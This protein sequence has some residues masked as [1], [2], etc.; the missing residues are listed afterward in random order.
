MSRS[1]WEEII[2]WTVCIIFGVIFILLVWFKSGAHVKCKKKLEQ[3]QDVI[4]EKKKQIEAD[5]K[6]K[7]DLISEV[8]YAVP[9]ADQ[10][11]NQGA[12]QH[13]PIVDPA[14]NKPIAKAKN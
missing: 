12:S 11:S 7:K 14:T 2:T 10:D 3:R 1:M 13:Y 9:D 5:K 8:Y 4:R 6:E